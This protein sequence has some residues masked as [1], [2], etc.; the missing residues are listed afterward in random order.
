MI[1]LTIDYGWAG[2]VEEEEL[3]DIEDDWTDAEI[4]QYVQQYVEDSIWNKVSWEW[5]RE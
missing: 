1:K 4:E 5:T 2:C 3:E